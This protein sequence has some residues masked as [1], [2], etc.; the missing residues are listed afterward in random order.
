MHDTTSLEERLDQILEVEYSFRNTTTLAAAISE[1][2]ASERGYAM[3]WVERVAS[4]NIEL[5]YQYACHVSQALASMDHHMVEAWALHAMDTYD[6]EGL[7]PALQVIRRLDRFARESHERASGCVLEEKRGVLLGFLQG[8]SGR[9]LKLE[10]SDQIYTDTET[11]FLPTVLARLPEEGDN[12]VLYKAMSV[13][14][15]AQIRYGTFRCPLLETLTKQ[16]DPARFLSLFQ[17]LEALRLDAVIRRELPGLHREMGRIGRLLG[18]WETADE[19][20]SLRRRLAQPGTS[21]AD[22]LCLAE[23]LQHRLEPC[24]PFPWQGMLQPEVVEACMAARL[25]REKAKFRVTLKLLEEEQDQGEQQRHRQEQTGERRFSK[26]EQAAPELP[27]G[28][29]TEILLD[30]KPMPLPEEVK[31]LISSIIVDLGEIPDEYL[32]PAGPGEYDPALFQDDTADPD[33]VWS[34]VYHEEGAH[35]YREWDYRRQHYRKNWCAVREKSVPPV[36]DTFVTETLARHIGLVKHLRRIFEAMRDEN[37]RLKRQN[38]GDDVDLDALVEALADARDGREMSER[39]FIRLHRTERNIAVIFMVD[40]SGSTKGWINDAE[41]ESLVLLCESL[42]ALGDR[43]AIYGFSSMT[44]KRCELYHIKHFEEPYDTEVKARISGIRPHDYTRM[45]FA[46]R[47]LTRVLNEVDAKTRIL[48]TLSDGK[49]DD[50][51]NYRGE[52]GI[53]DTRR[54][55]IEARREGVHPYCITIDELAREYLPHLYGPAA[56]TV[57]DDVRVLPMKVSDIYRR[58]TTV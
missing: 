38:H 39:L 1:L 55:L 22:V 27:E 15:W 37:R 41:R 23:E 42:E 47:H 7:R 18:D 32:E 58:L 56:Y 2:S 29:R 31:G 34:G 45:G 24:Q 43:Y 40:M 44:R 28:M 9:R 49:P 17:V 8:L 53:E 50:Y 13:S 21:A 16:P 48:I 3:D 46:I 30:G 10:E 35:L 6:R 36:Y 57:I 51:D 33:E 20:R 52:Y 11:I 5:G 26:R 12:F 14:L 19:W 4:T 54:A 25:E